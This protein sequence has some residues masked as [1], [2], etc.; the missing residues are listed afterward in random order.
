[1]ARFYQ[2]TGSYPKK[3]TVIGFEFKRQRF[4]E[5]HRAALKFP[6][7]EFRYIGMNAPH[8]GPE[9]VL[10]EVPDFF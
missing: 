9:T 3:I 8:Q 4:V 7:K 10:G 1:M 5:L 6:L 2:L